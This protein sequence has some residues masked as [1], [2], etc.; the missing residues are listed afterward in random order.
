MTDSNL[1][2]ATFGINVDEPALLETNIL[3]V[4]DASCYNSQDGAIDIR[5]DGGTA[6]FTASVYDNGFNLLYDTV[7]LVCQFFVLFLEQVFM[8]L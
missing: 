3:S 4:I 5:V 1:C 2:L 6:P 8:I 7:F